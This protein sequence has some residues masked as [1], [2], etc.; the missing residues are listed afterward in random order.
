MAV[1]N[2]YKMGLRA[3]FTGRTSTAIQAY[4]DEE[5]VQP[6]VM[7]KRNG[8]KLEGGMQC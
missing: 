4:N 1:V 3:E 5:I 7:D 8:N 6:T 2:V